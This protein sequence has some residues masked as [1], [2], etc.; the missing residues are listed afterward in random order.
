MTQGEYSDYRVVAAYSSR[1]KAKALV[2]HL[3]GPEGGS[4][5]I[6]PYVVDA[7]PVPTTGCFVVTLN[8]SGTVLRGEWDSKAT[9]APPSCEVRETA[10]EPVVFRGTGPTREHARRSAE[11]L[12]RQ[13]VVLYGVRGPA[14]IERVTAIR[15]QGLRLGYQGPLGTGEFKPKQE[16]Q[17]EFLARHAP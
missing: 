9:E 5:C 15:H 1:S 3:N 4:A 2:D 7:E 17:A 12:R 16:L 14:I 8:E 11:E 6:E 10:Y 13:E